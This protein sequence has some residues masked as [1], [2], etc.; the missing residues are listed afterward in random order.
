MQ[1][2]KRKLKWGRNL[3]HGERRQ[4]DSEAERHICMPGYRE[5]LN[6]PT[7]SPLLFNPSIHASLSAQMCFIER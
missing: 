2:D 5:I 4:K 7:R 6:G 1:I 3:G